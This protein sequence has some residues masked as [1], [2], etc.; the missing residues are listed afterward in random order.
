MIIYPH[1]QSN[2]GVHLCEA[3]GKQIHEADGAMLKGGEC[4][5]EEGPPGPEQEEP[6]QDLTEEQ[7][8]HCYL[9]LPGVLHTVD[10]A[11][12]CHLETSYLGTVKPATRVSNSNYQQKFYQTETAPTHQMHLFQ[13]TLDNFPEPHCILPVH[14]IPTIVDTHVPVAEGL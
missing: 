10:A 6:K 13:F 2:P 11:I 5:D 4:L 8:C 3:A 9:L 12:S 7:L 1:F 14:D